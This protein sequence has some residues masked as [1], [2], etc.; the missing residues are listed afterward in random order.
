MLFLFVHLE[1]PG[2]TNASVGIEEGQLFPWTGG[3]PPRP[4]APPLPAGGLL[5]PVPASALLRRRPAASIQ[6]V[7][8]LPLGIG[9]AGTC[10]LI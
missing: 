1:K 10:I 9:T 6:A 3:S 4:S 2:V 8:G 5:T 7:R